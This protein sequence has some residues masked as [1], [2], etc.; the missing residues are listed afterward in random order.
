MTIGIME[1]TLLGARDLQNTDCFGKIDPYV[2]IQYKNEAQKS[3]VARGRGRNPVL[4]NEKFRFNVEYTNKGIDHH[5][6][7][8]KLMDRSLFFTP[9]AFLGQTIIY[10]KELFEIGV[11]EGKAELSIKKY[12]VVSSNRTYH[13]EIK[14]GITFTAK[15]EIDHV[16]QQ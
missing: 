12:R 16:Q 15:E 2:L 8:L 13:G 11:E 10:L 4:W 14:V 3:C 1:V 9:D 7:V 5:K 6:L